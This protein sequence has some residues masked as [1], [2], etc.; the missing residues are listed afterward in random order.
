M[1]SRKIHL[2]MMCQN[3]LWELIPNLEKVLPYVDSVTLVDGGST[4]DT[5][6][7]MRNWSLEEPKIRFYVYPWQDDFPAQR[8][9]YVRHIAEIAEP[10]DWVL[11]ADP[12]EFFDTIAL[13]KLHR[14][15][16]RAEQTGKNMIG[17]QCRSVSLK[18][19]KRVWENLDDY[20]KHLFIRWDPN[21]HYTGYKCHEGKGGV[22]HNIMNTALIYEH[23]KQENVIWIRG[24]RNLWH[25]G[26][27]PN[28]GDKNPI[29]VKLRKVAR[30]KLSIEKWHD[31]YSYML[32]GNIDSGIKQI[33]IDHAYEGTPK[34]GPNALHN[35]DWDGSS[36]VREM[37]RTYFRILHPEEEPEAFKGLNLDDW[38]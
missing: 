38:S 32:R 16:Y 20:W 30:E 33:L 36:E 25:G 31:F 4:D 18:G 27:G 23:I 13:E 7:Y 26:G 24:F 1:T 12:D 22:P 11:T 35:N 9:N 8:N 19:N 29:W 34:A 3:N 10:G 15:A 5:I 6:I 21:F 37:Y 28:L 2:G 17:F 14:A